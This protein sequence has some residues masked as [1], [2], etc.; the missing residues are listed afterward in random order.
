MV[1]LPIRGRRVLGQPEPPRQPVRYGPCDIMSAVPEGLSGQVHGL[2]DRRHDAM[3]SC[4]DSRT[5]RSRLR[6]CSARRFGRGRAPRRA[7]RHRPRRQRHARAAESRRVPRV[8]GPPTGCPAPSGPSCRPSRRRSWPSSPSA[9]CPRRRSPAAQAVAGWV[10][11]TRQDFVTADLRHD[12][13]VTTSG[14][15]AVLAFPL[16]G[17]GRRRRARRPR[18]APVAER[19]APRAGHARG[20][21]R[22][23]SSRRRSRSTTRCC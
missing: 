22:R 3:I 23:C 12:A 9:G 11:Q 16:S 7:R 1:Y 18:S 13:R 14:R 21:A 4:R 8:A 2:R 5:C 17:R 6:A 15:G 20:L 19:A 10:M